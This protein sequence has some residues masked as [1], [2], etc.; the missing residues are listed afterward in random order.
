MAE[1]TALVQRMVRWGKHRGAT[2]GVLLWVAH[3][4]ER[5]G[6]WPG[7]SGEGETALVEDRLRHNI[8][9]YVAA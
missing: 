4:F 5:D 9:C 2:G 1:S 8:W 7:N 3:Q 6:L